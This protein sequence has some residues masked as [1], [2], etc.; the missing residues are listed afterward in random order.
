MSLVSRYRVTLA[1]VAIAV[2]AIAVFVSAPGLLITGYDTTTV[3][4]VDAETGEPL[5]TV[6]VRV[7]DGPIKR[8]V[9]LSTTAELAANEGM[10]FIH[11][12]PGEYGY[13]MRGM[14]FDIDIVFIAATGEITT[15]HEAEPESRPL[16][17]YRGRGQYV[18]E[19]PRG[20]SAAAGV[21]PGDTVTVET[22]K[23]ARPA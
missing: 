11:P 23:D 19:V 18:L 7:A 14:A 22:R 12:E 13:V 4:A 3:T 5:A 2:S 6:D 16:T 21:E 8:H 9:G 15:I 1:V 17:T 10:L 20:W